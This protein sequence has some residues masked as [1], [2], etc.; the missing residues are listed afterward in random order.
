MYDRHKE[1]LQEKG[2]EKSPWHTVWARAPGGSPYYGKWPQETQNIY[3]EALYELKLIN[4]LW[5]TETGDW[6]PKLSPEERFS[7][8]RISK[9][10]QQGIIRGGILV[11]HDRGPVE[12][13]SLTLQKH[14]GVPYY[15]ET[16][17]DQLFSEKYKCSSQ[18]AVLHLMK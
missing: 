4:V 11:T 10:L 14:K 7:V 15:Q 2:L 1:I 17:L 3:A 13:I 6:N 16:T 9:R 5:H 12:A 18:D 8:S